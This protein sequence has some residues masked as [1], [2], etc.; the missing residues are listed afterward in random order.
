MFSLADSLKVIALQRKL[1]QTQPVNDLTPPV[2][3]VSEDLSTL[4]LASEET[5]VVAMGSSTPMPLD[6]SRE[7][8]VEKSEEKTENEDTHN[9]EIKRLDSLLS[10]EREKRMQAELRCQAVSQIKNEREAEKKLLDK[11]I[12][13]KQE[14]IIS[15]VKQI[16]DT[17]IVN[18]QLSNKAREYES[19]VKA[20]MDQISELK[21]RN[22][23][24][25]DTLC[26][27]IEKYDN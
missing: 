8:P 24:L 4:T 20:K 14:T 6:E 17:K 11:D 15:L 16:E 3:T 5:E 27:M 22:Q 1:D 12:R 26:Q 10:Q 13:E 25:D 9:I 2:I 21:H 23:V 18:T 19:D 7:S